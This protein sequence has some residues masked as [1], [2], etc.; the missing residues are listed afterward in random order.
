[1][2][3]SA[4]LPASTSIGA[5]SSMTSSGS[6]ASS[7]ST[8]PVS[9]TVIQSYAASSS[10]ISVRPS[11]SSVSG[12]PPPFTWTPSSPAVFPS[13][14]ASGSMQSLFNALPQLDIA[15]PL[16]LR[17]GSSSASS[18]FS[19]PTLAGSPGI[20]PT[21]SPA[22]QRPPLLQ[23]QSS[24]ISAIAQNL[25]YSTHNVT[26]IVTTKLLAIEDY[27]PWRTQFESFLVS[28]GLLGIIDGSLPASPL[29]VADSFNIQSIHPG[30]YHWLRLDQTVRSWIFATLF[31][32]L[33]IDVHDIKNA[34]QIWERLQSRFMSASL[35]RS[36]ELKRMLS[37]MNL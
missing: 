20:L 26:A 19:G 37:H 36:L 22:V 18:Q 28:Q 6:M 29:Y 24:S 13:S 1:M 32:D 14:L 17:L 21:F 9:S 27:L 15:P 12:F 23:Q 5:S 11:S 31:R 25:G 35:N 33:L 16:H 34:A 2:A 10:P 8:F 7:T 4:S 3:S 30:Y